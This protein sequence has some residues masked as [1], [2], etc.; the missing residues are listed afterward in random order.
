MR[1][2]EQLKRVASIT[3]GSTPPT[4]E[5]RYYESEDI[6]WFTPGDLGDATITCKAG[7]KIANCFFEESGC[8]ML[9]SNS[10]LM[11]GIGA[12]VG[13]VGYVEHKCYANQQINAISFNKQKVLPKYGAYWLLDKKEEVNRTTPS[14]TLPI[15]N[16][17][18]VRLMVITYP[19]LSE[20][21]RIVDYLDAKLAAIDLRMTQLLEKRKLYERLK[22][23][24]ICRAVTRGLDEDVRLKDSGVEWIGRIPEHWKVSRLKNHARIV[25]GKMI[26]STEPLHNNGEYTLEKYLKARNIG[27]LEVSTAEDEVDSMWFN[28]YEKSIYKLHDGDIVMNEGGDIGK[29]SLWHDIGYDCY[30]QNSVNKITPTCDMNPAYLAYFLYHASQ[31]GYFWSIVTQ[32]SI[33]HLTKEKLSFTPILCP[34]LCEQQS[35]AAYLDE[36]C[37]KIDAAIC[38]IEKQVAALKRLKRALVHEV[39][40]GQRVPN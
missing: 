17:S 7:K 18:K 6:D 25:L 9:P 27:W 8:L 3:T 19:A 34:P 1:F 2:S 35:I 4:N 30:I 29:V 22:T 13:K 16:Q 24:T 12:T 11:V 28:D 21:Q 26:M 40:T 10:V 37:A 32:I 36:Q 5:P 23:A 33:A 15:C 14:V 39:I 31:Q 20:Q 38:L